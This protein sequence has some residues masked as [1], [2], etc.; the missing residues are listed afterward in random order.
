MSATYYRARHARAPSHAKPRNTRAVKA[1]TAFGFLL[2]LVT[3]GFAGYVSGNAVL[4]RYA[5]SATAPHGASVVP[6]HLAPAHQP[7]AGHDSPAPVSAP[8]SP[9]LAHAL[10]VW[11]VLHVK[12]LAHLAW[13]K[14]HGMDVLRQ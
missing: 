4:D 10:H 8:M 12:H 7:A 13:A 14:A 9:V 11:H 5:P 1:A 3:V 6:G 2:L